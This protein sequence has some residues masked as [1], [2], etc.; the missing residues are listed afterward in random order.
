MYKIIYTSIRVYIILLY[1]GFVFTNT[2]ALRIPKD[3]TYKDFMFYGF[4][5]EILCGSICRKEILC[6]SIC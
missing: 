2:I 4:R 5:K 6:G 3:G 1:P